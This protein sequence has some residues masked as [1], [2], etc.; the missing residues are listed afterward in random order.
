MALASDDGIENMA[1]D[2]LAV[3]VEEF[4]TRN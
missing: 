4:L 2:P 3:N 1:P